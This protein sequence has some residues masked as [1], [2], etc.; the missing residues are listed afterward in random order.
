MPYEQIRESIK[1]IFTLDILQDFKTQIEEQHSITLP[2]IPEQGAI[3]F[4][5]ILEASYIYH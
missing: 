2:N 4:E 5:D 1:E 3:N